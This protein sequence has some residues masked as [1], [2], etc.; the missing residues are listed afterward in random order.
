MLKNLYF[1]SNKMITS[2][3]TESKLLLKGII[4]Q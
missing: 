2:K 1:D 4:K 3:I